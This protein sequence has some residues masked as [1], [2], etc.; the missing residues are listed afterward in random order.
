M[1]T[2]GCVKHEDCPGTLL[3]Y[4]ASAFWAPKDF[5]NSSFCECSLSWG[6]VR[7]DSTIGYGCI[8]GLVRLRLHVPVWQSALQL[9]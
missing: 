1:M 9:F 3:C 5:H 4:D 8:L 6:L 2:F 7:E